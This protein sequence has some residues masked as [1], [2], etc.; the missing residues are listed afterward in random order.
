MP[1]E[2]KLIQERKE[3]IKKWFSNKENFALFLILAF[4]FL[5]RLYYFIKIGNQPLWWDESAYGSLAKN[6]QL[7]LW[8]NTSIIMSEK[9][10]RPPLFYIPWYLLMAVGFSETFIRIIL[11]FIPSVLTIFFVYLVGKEMY[12]KKIGLISAFIFSVL[13][14]HLFYTLRLLVHMPELLFLFS[15]IYYFIK[16]TKSEFNNKHF[17]ISIFLLSIATLV[18]YTNGMFFF[19]FF[20]YFIFS[21]PKQIKTKKFWLYS[22]IGLLP[23]LIFFI[24]NY[25][26]VGNIFPALFGSYLQPVGA[27]Q[28]IIKPFAFGFLN[29]IPLYL[30]TEYSIFSF[31]TFFFI[32]FILGIA[33]SLFE[34]F[35]AY[36]F[37]TKDKKLQ[38][39]LFLLLSLVVVCSFF[40]FYLKGGEDRYLFP[41]SLS[42]VIFS[43]LGIVYLT[44]LIRDYNKYLPLT[45]ILIILAFGA[46][47]Q[48]KFADET[49]QNKKDSFLQIK[50]G[51][52]WIKAN[53]PKD[54][55]L[56]GAVIDAYAPY[57]SERKFI[58]LPKNKSEISS[59]NQDYL[60]WHGFTEQ[61]EYL[62]DYLNNNQ[63]Q[64]QAVQA[65]FIDYQKKQ[66][67][68]II[69]ANTNK[70]IAAFS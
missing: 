61:P 42:L 2:E 69:F 58:P 12:S 46:Y 29:N 32:F 52:E 38:N 24:I 1:N 68:M 64:W 40:I 31:K 53:T 43:S 4:A 21:A 7:H 28:G 33:I 44:D 41:A 8:D 48:L 3:K 22:F 62:P 45:I 19:I 34:V 66:P 13:W 39:H 60:I 23:L 26:L 18:R 59:I 27:K 37:L 16:A 65:Y 5:I 25:F 10:I 50:Q 36:N 49:V 17:A 35:I 30:T 63:N 70:T 9:F 57:Y 51:F 14:I 67:L 20:V 54:A 11:E 6:L 56:T 55:V 47:S 15:S